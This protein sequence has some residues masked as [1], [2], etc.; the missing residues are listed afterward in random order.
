MKKAAARAARAKKGAYVSSYF[1]SALFHDTCHRQ[2]KKAI[3]SAM[4]TI[5]RP[6]LITP[7]HSAVTVA[8]PGAIAGAVFTI[9]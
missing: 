7:I 1:P 8:T 3:E 2:I 4:S 6:V 9:A 5:L